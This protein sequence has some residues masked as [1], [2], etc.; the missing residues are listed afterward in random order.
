MK[1]PLAAARHFSTQRVNKKKNSLFNIL[2]GLILTV[3]VVGTLSPWVIRFSFSIRVLLDNFTANIAPQKIEALTPI[4]PSF[5]DQ[6]RSKIDPTVFNI[7]EIK[8]V[9]AFTLEITS[10]DNIIAVFSSQNEVEN[11]ISSLQT[12]LAK[13]RI[14]SK[15]VKKI[16]LR[17]NKTVVEY[18]EARK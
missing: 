15:P 3:V 16:D 14:E 11:Q 13:S 9:D 2:V 17:F 1:Y 6:I 12:I 4:A 10:Q 7:K 18:I 8:E 5:T